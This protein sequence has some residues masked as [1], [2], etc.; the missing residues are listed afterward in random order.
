MDTNDFLNELI[1]PKSIPQ[2]GE[3]FIW[4]PVTEEEKKKWEYLRSS[5]HPSPGLLL[6]LSGRFYTETERKQYEEEEEEWCRREE[7]SR[8]KQ[9]KD[10]CEKKAIEQYSN[11]HIK[12]PKESYKEYVKILPQRLRDKIE[13]I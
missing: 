12:V 11:L 13:T 7:E 2:I 1:L 10:Y 3:W 9:L 5:V 6:L 8:R 4:S